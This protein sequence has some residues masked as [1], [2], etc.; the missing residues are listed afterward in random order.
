MN[1]YVKNKLLIGGLFLYAS[2]FLI[3]YLVR[4]I[5]SLHFAKD[6]GISNIGLFQCIGSY[7]FFLILHRG[8]I[9][10]I[11]LGFLVG[12]VSFVI[13]F[14]L[15]GFIYKNNSD[16]FHYVFIHQLITVTIVFFT[17]TCFLLIPNKLR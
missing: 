13:D 11:G 3:N 10:F 12:F 8:L 1:P 5:P 2:A 6:G 9:T 7:L 15:L 16:Y 14:F 17:G 4:T